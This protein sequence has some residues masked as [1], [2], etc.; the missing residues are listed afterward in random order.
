M[1]ELRCVDGSALR[2]RPVAARD[3]IGGVYEVRLALERD[4]RPFGVVGRGC[5][6]FLEEAAG[7]VGGCEG[8]LFAFAPCERGRETAELRCSV[9]TSPRWDGGA[10]EIARR[11]V[12]EAWGEDGAGV[13]VVLTEHELAD[14]LGEVLAEA[15]LL[16]GSGR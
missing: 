9:R 15:Q 3:R 12:I 4:G 11:A 14:F 16:R 8:E 1:G 10:W 13:R 5:G 7:R 6:Y 2:V